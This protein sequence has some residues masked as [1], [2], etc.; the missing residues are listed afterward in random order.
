MKG[1]IW[2]IF[3]SCHQAMLHRIVMNIIY[4]PMEILIVSDNML[5]KPSLPDSGLSTFISGRIDQLFLMK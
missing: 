3:D 5:P 1:G 2:P 4:M